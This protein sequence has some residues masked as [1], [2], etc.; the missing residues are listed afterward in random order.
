MNPFS[1]LKNG[2]SKS[3][4]NLAE[5]MTDI[6]AGRENYTPEVFEALEEM[7]IEADLGVELA[8]SISEAAEQRLRGKKVSGDD[9][10]G[11]L[12]VLREYMEEEIA[13]WPE[14]R[15]GEGQPKV[16]LVVG[17]N[18]VGKTTSV[19]KLALRYQNEG[20]RVLLVAADTFR[21]A[22]IDQ[23]C[24]WGDRLG[25]EVIK[26]KDGSD[27][28]A[29]VFDAMSAA[30]ARAVDVVLIDTAGRLHNKEHLMN[31]LAK[32]RRVI[33]RE[34]P[35]AP[36]E[37]L[38]VLDANTGQNAIQQSRVFKDATDVTGIVL[39]KLD[40]T[41]R[42]G[43]VFAICRELGIPVR[44]V[45]LGEAMEDLQPFAAESFAAALLAKE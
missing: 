24:I 37:V 8:L 1:K 36:H 14:P 29:V 4:R 31:E 6:F 43:V 19:A 44:Y 26:H 30:K 3:R 32:M 2:L 25:C 42:G 10:A 7:L 20:K 18:G 28:S 22:A 16:I 38:L 41:A 40:G 33:E 15:V 17:V 21:A 13:D 27:P 35:G 23:L 39:A 9:L 34:V 12:D 45:G 5:K 11:V